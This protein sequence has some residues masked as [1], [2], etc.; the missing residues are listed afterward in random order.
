MALNGVP[1]EAVQLRLRSCGFPSCHATDSVPL[2][3]ITYMGM[4]VAVCERCYRT[5]LRK[6][7]AP[8]QRESPGGEGGDGR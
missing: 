7:D 8:V 5:R 2:Y 4:V 6:G 3:L 1:I